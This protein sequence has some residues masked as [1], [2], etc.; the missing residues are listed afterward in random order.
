MKKNDLIQ[1]KLVKLDLAS[2]ERDAL[3]TGGKDDPLTIAAYT[4]QTNL[5]DLLSLQVHHLKVKELEGQVMS[6]Q[7]EQLDKQSEYDKANRK[8]LELGQGLNRLLD[9]LRVFMNTGGRAPSEE[10]IHKRAEFD[11][12]ITDQKTKISIAELE[13]KQAKSN[14]DEAKEN[15]KAAMIALD[16]LR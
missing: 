1:E 12:K 13:L 3:I 8:Y 10:N 16:Q 6:L 14:L 7:A 4:E 2:A 11:N 9:E 5:I 15:T